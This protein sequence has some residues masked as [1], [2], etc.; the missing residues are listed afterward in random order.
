MYEFHY[1]HMKQKY[2]GDRLQLLFTDTDSLTYKIKTDDIYQDME[3][4][5][6]EKYDFS[7]YP[8]DHPFFSNLNKKKIGYF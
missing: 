8:L 2:P 6:N 5:A 4:D 1:Y 3:I 7:A